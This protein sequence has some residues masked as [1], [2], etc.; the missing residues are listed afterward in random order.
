[1]KHETI[2]IVAGDEL[3][4]T[5]ARKL[6][7]KKGCVVVVDNSHP[8]MPYTIRPMSDTKLAPYITPS[9]KETR[10]WSKNLRHK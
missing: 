2:L 7:D 1:M 6:A 10:N 4:L 5:I 3:G 9:K 8:S